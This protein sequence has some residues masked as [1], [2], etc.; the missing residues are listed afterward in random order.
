MT[1]GSYTGIS[2][3]ERSCKITDA[4]VA[5][6]VESLREQHATLSKKEEGKPVE[7]GDIAKIKVK[8]IDNV[9]ADAAGSVDWRDVTVLAGQHTEDYEFDIHVIGLNIGEE[10]TVTVKYPDDYQY[11]SVAGQKQTYILKVEEIQ[12]RDLPALDDEFAKDLGT[13]V[14]VDDMKAKIREGLEK[15]VEQKARGEAKADVLKKIVENSTFDIPASMIEEETKVIF[16]RLGQKIGFQAESFEQIAPF[17]GMKGDDLKAKL[18]EEAVQSIKTS[19]A[20]GEITKKETLKVTEEQYTKAVAEMAVNM[21]RSEEELRAMI[22]KS[23]ARSRVESEILYDSA[24]EFL[25]EK[26]KIKKL[27]PVKLKEFVK[28]LTGYQEKNRKRGRFWLLKTPPFCINT[29]TA[30]LR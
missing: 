3:E 7:K 28:K 15:M 30:F 16:G 21:K 17:F 29:Y 26:S 22:E 6:E 12:K 2:V 23:N 5:E 9:A 11:K 4:D 25:Y 27:S 10:K 20:V 18:G 8:R 24:I 14:S 13:Y 1:L 19:L